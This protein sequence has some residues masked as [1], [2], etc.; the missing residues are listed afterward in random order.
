MKKKLLKKL[1]IWWLNEDTGR[2]LRGTESLEKVW[3]VM[4]K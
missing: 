4:F 3:K 1:F 2:E